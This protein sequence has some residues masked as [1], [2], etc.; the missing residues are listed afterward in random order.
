MGRKQLGKRSLT[1]LAMSAFL[2]LQFSPLAF[3]Q[4]SAVS[5]VVL[6]A[7]PQS[8]PADGHT[9]AVL[10]AQ[11]VGTSGVPLSGVSVTFATDL[12]T[13]ASPGSGTT[14][15]QGQVS[16]AVYSGTPGTATVTATAQGVAGTTTVDFY[17]TAVASVNVSASPS[18]VPADGTPATITAQ[19]L[20]GNG[21][22]VVG[23]P[24]S[25]STDSGNLGAP[26]TGVTNAQG[27]VTDTA[28]SDTPGT[29]ALV[30]A[31]AA[32]GVSGNT[33]ISFYAVSVSSVQVWSSLSDVPADGKTTATVTARVLNGGGQP[34]AGV[35]VNFTAS[36]GTL[37]P[38]VS[39]A[40][41][42]Q[43][44]V[45]AAVYSAAPG[46]TTVTATAAGVSSTA[47]VDFYSAK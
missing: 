29:A 11:V 43:G 7:S 33:T 23:V 28:Y 13:V 21:A 8:V 9:A 14:D 36:L 19:A 41:N 15:S 31:T 34:V 25:F 42:A 2:L 32:D 17:A 24:V 5:Q 16:I 45:S 20:N 3:M 38:P 18:Q 37:A 44:Q 6:S 27:V 40:T 46:Q 12:G 30:T 47:T 39:M 4:S 1:A 35:P 10:T 26:T 22:P